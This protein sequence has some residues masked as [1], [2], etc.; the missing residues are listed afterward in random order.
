M[1]SFED[2]FYHYRYL[3]PYNEHLHHGQVRGRVRLS[4]LSVKYL[5]YSA[6]SVYSKHIFNAAGTIVTNQRL[7]HS[8][9]CRD[10]ALQKIPELSVK[11]E[12]DNI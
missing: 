12:E 3:V 2:F 4:I 9:R 10:C 1:R 5:S 6:Q 11:E 8:K 7:F